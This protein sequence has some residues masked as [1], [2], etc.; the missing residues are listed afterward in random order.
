MTFNNLP[1]NVE[2]KLNYH[3]P[4]LFSIHSYKPISSAAEIPP[5]FSRSTKPLET[6]YFDIVLIDDNIVSNQ[7]GILHN[8]GKF[9]KEKLI[10]FLQLGGDNGITKT[11]KIIDIADPTKTKLGKI[12]N[13]FAV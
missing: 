4:R 6:K 2:V 11:A 13:H 7:L 1:D 5:F 3:S 10:Y 9:L 12:G 8:F